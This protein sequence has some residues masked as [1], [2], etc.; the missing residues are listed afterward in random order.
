M[1]P[2]ISSIE[3]P[4]RFRV[5][6]HIADG[7]MASVWSAEDRTLG[8]TV[9]IKLLAQRFLGDEVLGGGRIVEAIR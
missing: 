3:L 2:S 1:T 4:E 6:A 5:S 8:R 7:G 9:A